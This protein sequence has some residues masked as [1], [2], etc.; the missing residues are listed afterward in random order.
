PKT[1]PPIRPASVTTWRSSRASCWRAYPRALTSSSP[2]PSSSKASTPA[3]SA[4]FSAL[5]PESFAFQ[6]LR[7]PLL[8]RVGK[9]A[10]VRW[11]ISVHRGDDLQLHGDGGGQGGHFDGGAGGA[12]GGEVFGVEAVED[13]KILLHVGKE[14]GDVDDPVPGAA[15]VFED[16][17]HVLEDRS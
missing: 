6:K 10:R 17:L 8:L 2:F 7:P 14:D 12:V 15:G 4:R 5:S 16:H 3:P 11:A 1:S 9:I 13:G